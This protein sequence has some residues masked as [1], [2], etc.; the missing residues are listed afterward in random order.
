MTT[1]SSALK[2]NSRRALRGLALTLSVIVYLAGL[3]YAGV[4]SYSL[5]AATIAPDLL[6]LAVLGILAIKSV[7]KVA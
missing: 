5:F 1:V 4:R 7:A 6:P 3:L 2:D